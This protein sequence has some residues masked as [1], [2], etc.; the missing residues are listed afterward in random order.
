MQITH[1]SQNKMTEWFSE[2]H[3]P[4]EAGPTLWLLQSPEWPLV[5]QTSGC[6]QSLLLPTCSWEHSA[7]QLREAALLMETRVPPHLATVER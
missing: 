5:P 4:R 6:S 3:L 7:R 2:R 1:S